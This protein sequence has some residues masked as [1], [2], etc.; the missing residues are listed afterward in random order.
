[1]G[2]VDAVAVLRARWNSAAL[3]WTQISPRI[4]RAALEPKSPALHAL[5]YLRS[6]QPGQA[7]TG[8]LRRSETFRRLSGELFPF[9]EDVDRS[10]SLHTRLAVKRIS[11]E[12]LGLTLETPPDVRIE[13]AVHRPLT[14]CRH[15]III[16]PLHMHVKA[17]FNALSTTPP[18]AAL[19]LCGKI[20]AD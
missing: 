9:R 3:G 11:T 2:G 20:P 8:C 14:R 10:R 13:A 7:R 12:A 15:G 5:R 16:S 6:T 17:N 19:V 18:G 1:M 4:K